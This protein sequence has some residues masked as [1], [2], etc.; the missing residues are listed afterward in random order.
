MFGAELLQVGQSLVP[1][2]FVA[3]GSCVCLPS[4]DRLIEP[5]DPVLDSR[6]VASATKRNHSLVSPAI[7]R[8][9]TATG[10]TAR[11]ASSSAL[12]DVTGASTTVSTA[13][14]TANASRS[15]AAKIRQ[16]DPATITGSIEPRISRPSRPTN[17]DTEKRTATRKP[18]AATC[19]APFTD[20]DRQ[21]VRIITKD[22]CV[23]CGRPG[24]TVEHNIPVTAG[25]D[26]RW[27]NLA[28]AC[29]PC[30]GAKNNRPLLT[31]MLAR[32]A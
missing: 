12:P 10:T 16:S 25:G 14:R 18:S 1:L 17:S 22:P 26:N 21:Y 11:P 2:V 4:G 6:P 3:E 8:L 15:S 31:F 9:G 24:G 30:N 32:A 13:S 29:G 19:A 28:G 20:E 23:Y 5:P 27:T 7:S